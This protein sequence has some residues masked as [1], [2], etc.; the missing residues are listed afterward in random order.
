[1]LNVGLIG[2]GVHGQR[3]ARHLKEG[4]PG[5]RLAA[6]CR[7]NAAEAERAGRDLGVKW[8]AAPEALVEDPDVDAVLVVTPPTTHLGLVTLALEHRK[9]VL[10]EKPLTQTLGEA[11]DMQAYAVKNGTPIFLA[12][13]LRYNHALLLA[14]RELRR[15]APIRAFTASQRLPHA[16]SSWQNSDSTNPLGS[17]LNTGVHL[18]DLVRWMLGVDFDRV[19]CQA[20][21]VEN[22]FHEDLFKVQAALAGH[23][24]LVS[25]EI[26]KCT[27]SR[28]SNLEIVGAHGQVWV[29]YQVDSVTLLQ[30]AERIVLREAS[31][32][33]T[34]PHVLQDFA[35]HLEHGEVMPI[36]VLDGVRTLEVVE[37]CYRSLAENRPEP[38][39]RPQLVTP[40]EPR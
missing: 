9:P 30:G 2:L 16:D 28:S 26:A 40:P 34:L 10:V 32:T 5:L 31:P 35:H 13:T 20:Q 27:A 12:Q 38:V 4:V 21:R 25:L 39:S 29:D 19:Y 33:H 8:Y 1:M 15:I 24:A 7:R 22:P 17:I 23:D 14:R 11:Q 37:A 18:F 36:G 6:V 3:Y